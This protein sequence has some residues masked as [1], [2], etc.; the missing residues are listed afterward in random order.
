MLLPLV[1]VALF[2]FGDAAS[3]TDSFGRNTILPLSS[4]AYSSNPQT[5][6][7][8]IFGG[9]VRLM[10][11]MMLANTSAEKATERQVRWGHSIGVYG[12]ASQGESHRD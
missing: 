6:L 9:T 12:D 10:F 4:A 8:K 11:S 7:T 1:V 5:C 2:A 3:Y